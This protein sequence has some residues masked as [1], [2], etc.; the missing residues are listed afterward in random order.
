[1]SISAKDLLT[2]MQNGAKL[3]ERWFGWYAPRKKVVLI[4]SGGEKRIIQHSP[5]YPLVRDGKLK[6]IVWSGGRHEWE[7]K[8][9]V[10][11]W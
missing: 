11:P 6:Q 8:Q 10:N 1:M 7:L 4:T 3:Y 5:I 9:E 2:E